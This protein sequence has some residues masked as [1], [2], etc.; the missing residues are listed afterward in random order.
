MNAYWME[1]LMLEV[2]N[3]R[4]KMSPGGMVSLPVSA[5]R[6]LGMTPNQGAIIGIR[7]KDDGVLLMGSPTNVTERVSV[8]KR[9]QALLTGDARAY[10]SKALKRHYWLQLDDAQRTASL[11]TY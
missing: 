10:L 9:G 11:K 6:A 3:R 8:S 2:K 1:A 5:R 7:A 4:L